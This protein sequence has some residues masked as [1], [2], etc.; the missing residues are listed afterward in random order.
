MLSQCKSLGK[1]HGCQLKFN[2]HFQGSRSLS[3]ILSL[4]YVEIQYKLNRN[5][6]I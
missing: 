5:C 4:K 3:K 6:A 1:S 2:I